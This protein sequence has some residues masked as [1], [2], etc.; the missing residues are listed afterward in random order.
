VGK[1]TLR[2]TEQTL[3]PEPEKGLTLIFAPIKFG[4]IDYLIQKGTELGV[5]AFQPV[6]TRNTI[7]DKIKYDRLSA[8]AIEA[9]EQTGRV[10]LPQIHEIQTLEK[11][12]GG[13][14]SKT[15]IIFCDESGVA[16]SLRKVL[17]EMPMSAKN[18]AILIGPEGGFT[19]EEAQMLR[20]KKFVHS[21]SMGKRILRAETAALA[22][23][24]AFQA[25]K[26]DWD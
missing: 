9:A 26:G 24:G 12:I 6:K 18:F 14:D 16:E 19:A 1:G 7:I 2:I 25:I 8:N 15:K 5:T 22:A 13:W 17:E 11:L 21:A 4:K 3:K 10:T 23:L 20:A